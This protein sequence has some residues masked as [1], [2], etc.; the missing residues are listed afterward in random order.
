MTDLRWSDD[1]ELFG[2]ETESELEELE[3]DVYHVVEQDLGTNL[4]D[5]H[6]GLGIASIA[7]KTLPSG[8]ATQ[9]EKMLELDPRIDDCSATT[10]LD[11]DGNGSLDLEITYGDEVSTVTVPAGGG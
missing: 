5:L 8:L 7:S 10:N 2:A 9:A 6:R 11:G 4:D 1:L 3:Q